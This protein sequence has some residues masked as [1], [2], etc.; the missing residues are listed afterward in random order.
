[1][2]KQ[3]DITVL[4]NESRFATLLF[5]LNMAWTAVGEFSR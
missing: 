4:E 2:P 3:F 1:M 5:N